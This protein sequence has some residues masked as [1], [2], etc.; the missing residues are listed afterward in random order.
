MDNLNQYITELMAEHKYQ[1]SD[2]FDKWLLANWRIYIEFENH[3]LQMVFRGRTHYS[4]RTIIE[5]IRHETA[6]R[7]AGDGFKIN[8]NQ[9]P[10]MARLFSIRYPKHAGLF[11]YRAS[12]VH[13]KR[14]K[15]D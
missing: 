11:E 9:V 10:D 3:A 13:P 4:S 15:H 5:Y 14:V 6:L 7:E 12:K 8:N 2:D 1:F